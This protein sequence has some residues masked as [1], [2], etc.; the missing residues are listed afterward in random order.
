M[1]RCSTRAPACSI[2]GTNPK[3]DAEGLNAPEDNEGAGDKNPVGAT[4]PAPRGQPTI[5]PPEVNLT[6]DDPMDWSIDR[7][8]HHCCQFVSKLEPTLDTLELRAALRRHGVTGKILLLNA[9]AEVLRHDLEIH[10]LSIRVAILADIEKLK[11]ESPKYYAYIQRYSPAVSNTHKR[12]RRSSSSECEDQNSAQSRMLYLAE[13]NLKYARVEL[14]RQREGLE[15]WANSLWIMSRDNKRL[16]RQIDL[17]QEIPEG[18]AEHNQLDRLIERYTNLDEKYRTYLATTKFRKLTSESQ[19]CF[20]RPKIHEDFQRM[21]RDAEDVGQLI[22]KV[23]VSKATCE[24]EELQHL[25]RKCLALDL[26]HLSAMTDAVSLLTTLEA[27]IVI[28]ALAVTACFAWVFEADYPSFGES[29]LLTNYRNIIAGEGMATELCYYHLLMTAVGTT[30]LR[31]IELAARELCTLSDTFRNAQVPARARQLSI[32][33]S[34]ALAPLFVENEVLQQEDFDGF[35]IWNDDIERCESIRRHVASIFTTALMLK[36]ELQL[37]VAD[38]EFVTYP[39]G[40]LFDERDML[41]QLLSESKHG[42]EARGHGIALCTMP[43]VFMRERANI[44][45]GCP[46][47]DAI[48]TNI[49]CS[50]KEQTGLLPDIRANVIVLGD[51]PEIIV[52]E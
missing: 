15:G 28:Q 5:M 47:S 37:N 51:K 33:L 13:E 9:N 26:D 41:T 3:S 8:T 7:V 21:F 17:L 42:S 30:G 11:T 4:G 46:I 35:A 12:R 44:D 52:L 20:S 49:F 31:N 27:S 40:T 18:C 2:L 45:N 38:Y 1:P 36:A 6:S 10:I 34:W 29:E 22:G 50:A 25:I 16:Q 32:R 23:L 39:S 19:Q 43:A 48:G 14:Q 24:D